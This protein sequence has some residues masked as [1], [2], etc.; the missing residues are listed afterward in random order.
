MATMQRSGRSP[1]E[2]IASLP[3]EVRPDI[4]RLDHEIS[5]VMKGHER[6][7]WEGKFWGGSDQHIIGYGTYS[8]EG[9]SGA[10]GEWYVVGLAAQ[11][12]YITVFVV[13]VEDGVYLAEAYKDRLGKAKIGK[14]S[15]SFKRL[16]D[17]EL[18]ALV[19]LIA[20][21]RKVQLSA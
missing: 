15:I 21:A 19:E 20:R 5:R 7:L 18:P 8:Y 9:R 14:S 11:K 4:E 13:A 17:I 3:D 10:S 12:N 6:V 2:H 1:D 16:S